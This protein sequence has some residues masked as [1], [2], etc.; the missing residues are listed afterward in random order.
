MRILRT[1]LATV[2]HIALIGEAATAAGAAGL[3]AVRSPHVLLIEEVL[4]VIDRIRDITTSHPMM[5]ISTLH[6]VEEALPMWDLLSSGVGAIILSNQPPA[7]LL[8]TIE[9]LSK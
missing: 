7:V 6:D 8:A 1:T 3:I 9:Y 5:K 4:D 2:P